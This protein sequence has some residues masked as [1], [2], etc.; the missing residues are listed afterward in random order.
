MFHAQQNF[1]LYTRK[2]TIKRKMTNFHDN[3]GVKRVLHIDEHF[4]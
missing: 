3:S 2:L 4:T 1:Q